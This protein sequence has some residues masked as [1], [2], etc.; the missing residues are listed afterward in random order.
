MSLP[1]ST[2]R[3]RG[4]GMFDGESPHEAALNW[5]SW[6]DRRSQSG[7]AEFLRHIV[8]PALKRENV[9]WFMFTPEQNNRIVIFDEEEAKRFAAMDD[10][11]VIPLSAESALMVLGRSFDIR[12]KCEPTQTEC[13]RC[14]NDVTKCDDAFSP[15][16]S[17]FAEGDGSM[18][19]S[20]QQAERI[21]AANAEPTPYI[22][23]SSGPVCKNC[24]GLAAE[25]TCPE[26]QTHDRQ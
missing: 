22:P 17:L 12:A 7:L 4:N 2:T 10:R 13:Q 6:C 11:I 26:C 20:P 14:K 1:P 23:T 25:G 8:A 5:A 18:L 21:T 15:Q 24:N 19:L 16:R 9:A 3:Y